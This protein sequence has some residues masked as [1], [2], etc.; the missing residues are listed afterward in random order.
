MYTVD[1]E[2]RAILK[3]NDEKRKS[4]FLGTSNA[5]GFCYAF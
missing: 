5:I 1:G 2:K 4:I 3:K